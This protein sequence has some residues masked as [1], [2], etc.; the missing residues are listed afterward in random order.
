MAPIWNNYYSG[1]DALIFV[2]DLANVTQVTRALIVVAAWHCGWKK[3]A[4]WMKA[5]PRG[6]DIIVAHSQLLCPPPQFEFGPH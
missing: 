5:P 1:C 6:R 2:V 4:R 3:L